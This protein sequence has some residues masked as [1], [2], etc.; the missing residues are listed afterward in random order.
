MDERISRSARL[1]NVGNT[2]RRT[3]RACDFTLIGT[4]HF[5]TRIGYRIRT[6]FDHMI[7]LRKDPRGL[8]A[9]V[10]GAAERHGVFVTT[11]AYSSLERFLRTTDDCAE[12]LVHALITRAEI[13]GVRLIDAELAVS[14]IAEDLPGRIADETYA[15]SLQRHLG[16]RRITEV[17]DEEVARINNETGWGESAVR[18]ALFLVIHDDRHKRGHAA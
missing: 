7:H 6:R 9:A 8:R 12:Q 1:N 14:V 3:R 17:S 11:D 13:E 10:V 4:A 5:I 16:G 15:T 18:G 2:H